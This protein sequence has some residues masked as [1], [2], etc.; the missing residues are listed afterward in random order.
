MHESL[1]IVTSTGIA[2][3]HLGDI[4]R[5]EGRLLAGDVLKHERGV[6]A[7][8]L[9]VRS[10]NRPDPTWGTSSSD[11]T[12]RICWVLPRWIVGPISWMSRST[13]DRWSTVMS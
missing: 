3:K 6:L 2:V 11:V 8:R 4:A 9:E 7:E 12:S 5:V 10:P 1:D 13:K